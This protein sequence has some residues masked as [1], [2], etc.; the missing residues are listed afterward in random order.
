MKCPFFQIANQISG[1]GVGFYVIYLDRA[2]V[3]CP[4]GTALNKFQ[5]FR[6]G[7]TTDYYYKYTCCKYYDYV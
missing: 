3:D 1:G 2:N 6:V 4:D 5:W 7:G